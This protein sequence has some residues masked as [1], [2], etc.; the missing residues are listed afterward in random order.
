MRLIVVVLRRTEIGRQV[1]D[2]VARGGLLSD[3][4]MLKVVTSKLDVVNNNKVC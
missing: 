2:T 3:E 4:L 1:E